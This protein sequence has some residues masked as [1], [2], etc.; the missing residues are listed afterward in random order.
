MVKAYLRYDEAQAFGVV[1]TPDANVC[2]DE[3]GK[4]LI[5][6]A[7]ER[8]I[9]WDMRRCTQVTLVGRLDD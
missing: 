9:I 2:Y 8:I 7:L 1:A 4:H 5:T 6:A 3:S